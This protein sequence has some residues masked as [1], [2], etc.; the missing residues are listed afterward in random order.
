MQRCL[1]YWLRDSR[2]LVSVLALPVLV[3]LL[4]GLPLLT[5]SPRGFAL[6]AGPVLALLLAFTM[7]NE[8][9]LDGSAIWTSLA[10]G[11]RGRDDRSARVLALLVWAAPSTVVVAVLGTVVAG[12]TGFA[13]AAVG[14]SVGILLVG[15]GL[16][17]V[18]SVALPFSVPPAGS[19]PFAGNPGSTSGALVQQGLSV[20]VLVPLLLPLVALAVWA[21]F[22]P[23]LGWVLVAVG[24]AYGTALLGVGVHVGGGLFDRRGPELLTR[25]R[26]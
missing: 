19:N 5:G 8:L 1:R 24:T 3:L 15:N 6:V 2:Y 16:A 7:L 17:A 22:T 4:L 12:R 13:P 10:A 11:V 21:W 23:V 25:L 18:A 14:L 26:R 9:A 20:L